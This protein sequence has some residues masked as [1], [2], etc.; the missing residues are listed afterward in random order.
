MKSYFP[1]ETVTRKKKNQ[2]PSTRQRLEIVI[3]GGEI[4]TKAEI[5][6]G[7]KRQTSEDS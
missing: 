7:G 5:G 1:T 6:E 2:N 3:S 4:F